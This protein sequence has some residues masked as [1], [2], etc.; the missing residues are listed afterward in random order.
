MKWIICLFKGHQFESF[1]TAF[2]RIAEKLRAQGADVTT[3][4]APRFVC[5]RC[6]KVR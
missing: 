3:H 6:G 5:T 2:E 1:P 4:A